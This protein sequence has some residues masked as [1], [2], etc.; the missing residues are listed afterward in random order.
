MKGCG[1]VAFSVRR[2]RPRRV[3]FVLLTAKKWYARGKEKS[4]QLPF[5]V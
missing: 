2:R 3:G 5:M 1:D 4:C